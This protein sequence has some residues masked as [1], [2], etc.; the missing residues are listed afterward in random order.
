MKAALIIGVGSGLSASIAR[1]LYARGLRLIL[2]ARDTSD[3]AELAQQTKAELVDCDASDPE[4]MRVLF[5]TVDAQA[6]P[7]SVAIYNPSARLRGP[8]DTLDV[9]AVRDALMVTAY[10]AFLM[11]HHAA[12]RM[13]TNNEGT[14]LFTGASAGIKGFA[15][16][17]PFAMGKFALRGLTQSL[18][19]E[20]HPKGIH[21]AHVAIDGGIAGTPQSGRSHTSDVPDDMLEPDAIAASYMHLI[22]QHRSAWSQEMELRPLT[23]IF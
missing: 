13:L 10:G 5:E 4:D 22:D 15:N 19:R 21:V 3:L 6:S 14:M 11:A 20:L 18:A 9:D 1:V 8:I 7:L 12:P 17:A 2:A 16:S 23:E